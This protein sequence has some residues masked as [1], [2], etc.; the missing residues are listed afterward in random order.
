VYEILGSLRLY[1]DVQEEF[2]KRIET[3]FPAGNSA[4]TALREDSNALRQY[5][6]LFQQELV[7]RHGLNVSDFFPEGIFIPEL[8]PTLRPDLVVL[9]QKDLFNTDM[10]V[11]LEG[12]TGRID[13]GWRAEVEH[14]LQLPIRMRSWRS[15][16]WEVM[17]ESVHQRVQSFSELATALYSFSA[18]ALG[19]TPS[20]ARTARLSP[21]LTG[22]LR[23]AR[24]DDEM[25]NFLRDAVEYLSSFTDGNI[26]V[27]V[28]IIRAMN[29][30]ERIAQIEES[31]LP[32]GKQEVI[33][34]CVL[35]MARLAGENG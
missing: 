11:L 23:S 1:Q 28:S 16:I 9:L 6:P 21:A 8:L 24:S 26:E 25:R 20:A 3:A 10:E 15:I 35:Q 31:A 32:E 2:L 14:A 18:N 17:G 4:F 12:V 29:D 22:F 30:V 19:G 27:P 33:R 13:E 34:T 5:L 7:R